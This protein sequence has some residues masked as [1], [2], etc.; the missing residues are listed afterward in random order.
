MLDNV[1]LRYPHRASGAKAPRTLRPLPLLRFAVSATGGAHL[2]SIQYYLRF[3]LSSCRTSLTV[4]AL[5]I[6]RYCPIKCALKMARRFCYF[7]AIQQKQPMTSFLSWAYGGK[8]GIRTLEGFRGP[9]RFPV[10]RLRP[11]QPSFHIFSCAAP[12]CMSYYSNTNFKCQALFC[13]F[14]QKNL[15]WAKCMQNMRANCIFCTFYPLANG[16]ARC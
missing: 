12:D 9:T 14:L 16:G 3:W 2:C 6:M 1:G 13:I 5:R 15:R 4:S 8:K 10:V 11:A 7:C